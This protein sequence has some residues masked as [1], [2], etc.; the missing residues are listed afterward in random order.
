[1]TV[2]ADGR[3]VLL[4]P[5]QLCQGQNEVQRT[6]DVVGDPRSEGADLR[7]SFSLEELGLQRRFVLDQ[8]PEQLCG[9]PS[10][11]L[12]ARA[13]VIEQKFFHAGVA[14]HVH[15]EGGAVV[16]DE[17]GGMIHDRNF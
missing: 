11:D 14:R 15:D 9:R 13:P 1:M 5:D 6:V 17:I 16:H 3:Q 4:A 2:V 7:Q 10:H 12:R 8:V